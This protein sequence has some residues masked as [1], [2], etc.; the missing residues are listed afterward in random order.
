LERLGEQPMLTTKFVALFESDF[1]F[2]ADS[3]PDT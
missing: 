1:D 2:A 3:L